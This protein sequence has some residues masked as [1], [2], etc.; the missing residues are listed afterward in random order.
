MPKL[1]EQSSHGQDRRAAIV[2]AAAEVW[3][4]QGANGF[5]VAAVARR[6]GLHPVSLSHYFRTR[7]ELAADCMLE[8]VAR[9]TAMA[10]AAALQPTARARVSAYVHAYLQ[11]RRRIDEGREPALANF[12]EIRSIDPSPNSAVLEAFGD[13]V[14]AIMALTVT[15]PG[16]PDRRAPLFQARLLIEFTGWAFAWLDL[17]E[18]T[19][20][21]AVAD[22]MLDIVFGGMAGA[23]QAWPTDP[24][25]VLGEA[26]GKRMSRD[27]L[28]VAAT[29]MINE[30]GFNGASIDAIAASLN[31]TKGSFYHHMTDKEE[32]LLA[33]FD[34]SF[35]LN[36]EAI[37]K[38]EAMG[39][40]WLRVVAVA[41]ALVAHHAST[42]HGR[43]LRSQALAALVGED[44]EAMLRRYRDMAYRL[45]VVI[46]AGMA[47]GSIRPVDPFIASALVLSMVNASLDLN[48]WMR[49]VETVD[50]LE[51]F[52]CPAL[53]GLPI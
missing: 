43:L 50:L 12:G 53:M 6:V 21:A 9:V 22:R 16:K 39:N 27:R 35:A 42:E 23:G 1:A 5:T 2:A 7:D 30:H 32:L 29:E 52:A 13:F 36:R 20:Y 48:H 31:V 18:P 45:A 33:C 25:P 41:N 10:Q 4:A 49:D 47:D 11:M 17:Y 14:R 19:E 38:S 28:V 40:G 8:S 15:D 44:R 24:P 37:R 46:S 26:C 3:N 51:E 34:H